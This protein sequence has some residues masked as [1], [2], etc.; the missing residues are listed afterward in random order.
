MLAG[1]IIFSTIQTKFPGG[2]IGHPKD[3]ERLKND[4]NWIRRFLMHH[5]LDKEKALSMIIGALK[6][7]Q[8]FGA[9]GIYIHFKYNICDL[10]CFF[11]LCLN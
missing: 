3:Q 5:E 7:R 4:R 9:N 10:Y 8:K 6:W 11:L 1:G 2:P